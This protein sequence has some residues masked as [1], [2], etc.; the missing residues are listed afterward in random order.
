MP[1][2][3]RTIECADGFSWPERSDANNKIVAILQEKLSLE[4]ADELRSAPNGA[5]PGPT[6]RP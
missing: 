3:S 4:K 5:A 1:I 2:D 6:S